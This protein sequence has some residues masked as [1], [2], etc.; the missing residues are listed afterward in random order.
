MKLIGSFLCAI[1]ACVAA[2]ASA[3]APP[4][5]PDAEALVAEMREQARRYSPRTDR[6]MLFT[7]AQVKYGLERDDYLHRWYDR[8]LSTDVSLKKYQPKNHVLNPEGWKIT[9]ADLRRGGFD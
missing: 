9:A 7:R 6:T 5:A 1:T 2:T 4:L 8:P 3:G